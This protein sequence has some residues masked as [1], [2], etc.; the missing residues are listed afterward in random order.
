MPKILKRKIPVNNSVFNPPA[1]AKA[2]RNEARK[3]SFDEN[4]VPLS[5]RLNSM[6][7]SSSGSLPRTSCCRDLRLTPNSMRRLASSH[8]LQDLSS[9]D[10]ECSQ[11]HDEQRLFDSPVT[12]PQNEQAT[13]PW[14]YFVDVIPMIKE[15]KCPQY[16]VMASPMDL[17]ELSSFSFHPYCKPRRLPSSKK[18]SYLP[19]FSLVLPSA[20]KKSTDEVEGALK[21]LHM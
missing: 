11:E 10:S 16:Q 15:E 9:C 2:F 5:P 14:G 21:R 1:T 4:P 12:S 7:S 20:S 18:E 3:I 8:Y 13:S 6:N 17:F 19:S